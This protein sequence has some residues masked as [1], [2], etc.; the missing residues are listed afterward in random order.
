MQNK[1]LLFKPHWDYQILNMKGKTK[2]LLVLVIKRRHRANGPFNPG[3]ELIGLT[4]TRS[5]SKCKL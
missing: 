1:A 5:T 2:G 4:G 3:L